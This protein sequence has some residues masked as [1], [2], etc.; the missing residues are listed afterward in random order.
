MVNLTN[1]ISKF[2]HPKEWIEIMR[3][4]PD[5]S[6]LAVGSHDNFIYLYNTKPDGKYTPAGKL[7]GHSS[8]ITALDWSQ[9]GDW[10]RS[11]CGAYE[12]LFFDPGTRK[13]VPGGASATVATQWDNHTVKFGWFVDGIYPPGTDGSHINI[14][15]MSHDQ[16]LIATGDDYG[17]VNLYRSPCREDHKARSYR[18][19]SEHVT[20]VKIW[21]DT[22]EIM[23][24]LGGQDQTLIQWRQKQN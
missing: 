24:S 17:L 5:E 11:S 21:G 1:I 6:K 15:E 23:C 2:N 4:N 14:V 9:D 13:Q 8:Y 7:K 3:Y 18:G 19:H 20:N 22:A 10:I 16:Q 12:L